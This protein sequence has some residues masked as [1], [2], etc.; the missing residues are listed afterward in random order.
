MMCQNSL[1]TPI[2]FWSSLSKRPSSPF[3]DISTSQKILK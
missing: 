3:V 1:N 2:P